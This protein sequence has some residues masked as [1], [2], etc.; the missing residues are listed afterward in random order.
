MGEVVKPRSFA[1]WLWVGSALT[2][3]VSCGSNT[4]CRG[5]EYCMVY[6]CFAL[7]SLVFVTPFGRYGPNL[8]IFSPINLSLFRWKD[9]VPHE[10]SL[11]VVCLESLSNDL[12]PCGTHNTVLEVTLNICNMRSMQRHPP[13]AFV[14]SYLGFLGLSMDTKAVHRCPCS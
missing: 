8:L 3:T 12:N 9:R 1:W 11:L 10:F 2:W 14:L 6:V 7:T 4:S 13:N 5:F